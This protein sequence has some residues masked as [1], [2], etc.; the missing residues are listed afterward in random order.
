MVNADLPMVDHSFPNLL[1]IK[2][3]LQVLPLPMSSMVVVGIGTVMDK[4]VAHLYLVVQHNL[5]SQ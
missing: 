3:V 1:I 2:D 4:M 5:V